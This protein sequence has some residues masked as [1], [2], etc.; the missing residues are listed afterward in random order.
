MMYQVQKL[1]DLLYNGDIGYTLI[2]SR[3]LKECKPFK[4]MSRVKLRKSLSLIKRLGHIQKDKV[5]IGGTIWQR[6]GH[7]R[8]GAHN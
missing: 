3:H 8:V 6:L 4:E 5:T 7:V 2:Y 1:L